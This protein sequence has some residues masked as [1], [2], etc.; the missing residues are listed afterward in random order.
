MPQSTIQFLQ[1]KCRSERTIAEAVT[2]RCLPELRL[3]RYQFEQA[4]FLTENLKI[5]EN[6]S[7]SRSD[8]TSSS[9]RSVMPRVSL[10]EK[11]VWFREQQTVRLTQCRQRLLPKDMQDRDLDSTCVIMDSKSGSSN[12]RITYTT[13]LHEVVA[14]SGV[15]GGARD[16]ALL[17]SYPG[18]R[19]ALLEYVCEHMECAPLC[20]RRDLDSLTPFHIAIGRGF[21][22]CAKYMVDKL[23]V[24]V[25]VR[26]TK[27]DGTAMHLACQYGKLRSV[28]FLAE[29]CKCDVNPTD[30]SGLTPLWCA[31]SENAVDIVRYLIEQR[32]VPHLMD[33]TPGPGG[34]PQH[35]DSAFAGAVRNGAADVVAYFC[36]ELG[37]NASNNFFGQMGSFEEDVIVSAVE[38]GNDE[39]V[40]Y[41]CR[42]D[43]GADPCAT[44]P[45]LSS[46]LTAAAQ[47][48]KLA[49][50]QHFVEE[51]KVD[52]NHIDGT[53]D[54]A[55][56]RACKYSQAET[57][58]YLC[59]N[60]V[61]PCDP[62]GDKRSSYQLAGIAPDF[63][64]RSRMP[65]MLRVPLLLAVEAGAVE[66]TRYLIEEA[67]VDPTLTE[68]SKEFDVLHQQS[69][70]ATA[71]RSRAADELSRTKIVRL[72]CMHGCS[73]GALA[74]ANCSII[75]MVANR[76][77]L[78]LLMLFAQDP[79]IECDLR[80]FVC[81]HPDQVCAM[82]ELYADDP[83]FTGDANGDS[84]DYDPNWDE[85]K[86]DPANFSTENP[87]PL[88][89][90][91]RHWI[92]SHSPGS[93][94]I[95]AYRMIR[96][97]SCPLE[98]AVLKH[99]KDTCNFLINQIEKADFPAGMK[100]VCFASSTIYAIRSGSPP[101]ILEMLQEHTNFDLSGS[102]V[103]SSALCATAHT[104]SWKRRNMMAGFETLQCI[105][106]LRA[107]QEPDSVQL[108][109]DIASLFEPCYF[110]LPA[111]YPLVWE[112]TNKRH[113]VTPLV[114]A[115]MFG[116]KASVRYLLE[117]SKLR[118]LLRHVQ[119]K[120]VRV[121]VDSNGVEHVRIR[122]DLYKAMCHAA[123]G[124]GQ[125]RML[126]YL[127][128]L[129]QVQ[130]ADGAA[131]DRVIPMNQAREDGLRVAA[132]VAIQCEQECSLMYCLAVGN[133]E[134]ANVSMMNVLIGQVLS[135]ADQDTVEC[136]TR[137]LY[138]LV[139]HEPRSGTIEKLL[140]DPTFGIEPQ[141]LDRLRIG[142]N[143]TGASIS[144]DEAKTLPDLTFL[145][146]LASILHCRQNA[147]RKAKYERD[148]DDNY[149]DDTKHNAA[150]SS[151]RSSSSSS[152]CS[153]LRGQPGRPVVSD[154][155]F[156]Q[157]I[158]AEERLAFLSAID[159]NR[160]REHKTA[161]ATAA[162]GRT[163]RTVSL[164][165]HPLFD[166][167]VIPMIFDYCQSTLTLN[168]AKQYSTDVR[169]RNRDLLCICTY[170]APLLRPPNFL[171][172]AMPWY[173]QGMYHAFG[174]KVSPSPFA[175]PSKS[176][177]LKHTLCKCHNLPFLT[178]FVR[179]YAC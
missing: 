56:E 7:D 60:T 85:E 94:R 71:I 61:S 11:R 149:D 116:R 72:L 48:G 153:S 30:K 161:A 162:A 51:L 99:H 53:G 158:F 39:L 110:E 1:E 81:S 122:N 114:V 26:D 19:Y 117:S 155:L 142:A 65:Y 132:E 127:L 119:C 83:T 64:C 34:E 17:C 6:G 76:G 70:L 165:D 147:M 42:D 102:F 37:Y 38:S 118:P 100:R 29:Y 40:K 156:H 95:I 63:V 20:H 131:L 41:L 160:N 97:H 8:S 5:D 170:H 169:D 136:A 154:V 22:M 2:R 36:E 50:L 35:G 32:K 27:Q 120:N 86:S 123:A 166:R 13:V 12:D 157:S 16:A 93:P 79:N 31:A 171:S 88:R 45:D 78:Q 138:A 75:R 143:G 146:P 167:N 25:D 121:V 68:E 58:Q 105:L 77:L 126:H 80:N 179:V 159:S 164:C 103:L 98:A 84:S 82:L 43:V 92:T 46:G 111:R 3:L 10:Y 133:A 89:N 15:T 18:W 14:S 62:H 130:V 73:A 49:L 113:Q 69:A 134:C 67:G 66:V 33:T 152:H 141:F 9:S 106:Q 128:Y 140:D 177:H 145:F 168:D 74:Y 129:L 150:H 23:H 137:V 90:M 47:A 163:S 174:C 21:I 96:D 108:V 115:C 125:I 144:E 4:G 55:L 135:R 57:V 151:S 178:G 28:E 112:F 101:H 176:D 59:T 175:K 139:T 54:N 52:V 173:C 107:E 104:Q 148:G 91:A 44:V 172:K 109:S 124:G 87:M 24:S